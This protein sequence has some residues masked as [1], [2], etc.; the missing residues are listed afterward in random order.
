[1]TRVFLFGAWLG[2]VLVASATE[3][4][5]MRTIAKG[6]FS[7]IQE[8]KQ[9]VV[10]NAAQ[11]TEVWQKHSVG[12]SPGEKAPEADFEK[13]T[14]IFVA[15]GQQRTGGYG[16][17]IAEVKRVE[18]KVKVLVKT[19]K[20]KP[21]GIQLQAISAPFHAVAVPKFSGEAIFKQESAER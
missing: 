9:L 16:I 6:N 14:V 19:R 11:W 2:I 13:E 4:E 20:P 1:M 17:E 12:K 10:T 3:A 5:K 21:G 15:L 8:A 18:G 7:G